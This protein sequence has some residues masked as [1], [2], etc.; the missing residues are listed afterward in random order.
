MYGNISTLKKKKEK[1]N[2][3]FSQ[4]LTTTKVQKKKKKHLNAAA[5]GGK[6]KWKANGESDRLLLYLFTLKTLRTA[7]LFG[8]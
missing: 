2:N 7:N 4:I 6:A 3:C 1:K 8:K 5:N